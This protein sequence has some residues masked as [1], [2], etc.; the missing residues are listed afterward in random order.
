MIYI[1]LLIDG[2]DLLE[3]LDK[4]SFVF[5]LPS[6]NNLYLKDFGTK[7]EYFLKLHLL[8]LLD[9]RVEAIEVRI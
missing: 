2:H 8:L 4:N 7:S 1:F 3:S 9:I 5:L 6:L